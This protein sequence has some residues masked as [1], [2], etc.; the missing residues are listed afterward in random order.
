MTNVILPWHFITVNECLWP[1]ASSHGNSRSRRSSSTATELHQ[2]ASQEPEHTS[3]PAHTR[4]YIYIYISAH[5]HAS[6]PLTPP[7]NT[8]TIAQQPPRRHPK[9]YTPKRKAP[10]TQTHT[11]SNTDDRTKASTHSRTSHSVRHDAP[12]ADYSKINSTRHART[13]VQGAST[14]S[15]SASSGARTLEH[16]AAVADDGDDSQPQSR[17]LRA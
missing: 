14:S 15:S 2:S 17:S 9:T 13:L 5:F 8:P 7:H 6:Q 1:A 12:C 3:T 16:R 4:T 10:H 11:H